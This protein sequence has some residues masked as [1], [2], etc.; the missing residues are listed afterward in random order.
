[1][2]RAVTAFALR[3][4]K[5]VAI[6]ETSTN[7]TVEGRGK[8]LRE[9]LAAIPRLRQAGIPLV[10]YTW[11]PLFDL[12]DWVYRAGARPVEDFMARHAPPALDPAVLPR[13]MDLLGWT[14]LDNLPLEAYLAPMGLYSLKM[15]FDGT[16]ARVRTPVVDEFTT[17]IRLGAGLVGPV[18]NQAGE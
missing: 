18:S 8:W 14:T 1:M 10:G 16:F 5:P 13:M 12:V 15:Q 6:T 3:Y 4:G 2:E 7:N 9:S 17:A 11:W